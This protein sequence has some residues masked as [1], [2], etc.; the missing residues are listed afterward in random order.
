MIRSHLTYFKN[1]NCHLIIML[2]NYQLPTALRK[3]CVLVEPKI[4][5]VSC[6]PKLEPRLRNIFL[7]KNLSF[8]VVR[9]SA[10]WQR[11]YNQKVSKILP[12]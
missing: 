10:K 7:E 9:H 2:A 1:Y 6:R 5:D 3:L 4:V 11:L 12:I 8:F